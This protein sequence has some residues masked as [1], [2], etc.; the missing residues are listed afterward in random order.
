MSLRKFEGLPLFCALYIFLYIYLSLSF[1]L[2]LSLSLSRSIS[3][4]GKIFSFFF[5]CYMK[6]TRIYGIYRNISTWAAVE[7]VCFHCCLQGD[8]TDGWR[9]APGGWRGTALSPGHAHPQETLM[10]HLRIFGLRNVPWDF[11]KCQHHSELAE[12]GM[13]DLAVQRSCIWLGFWRTQTWWRKD[14]TS[15]HSQ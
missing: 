15:K 11:T 12:S 14:L 3:L 4:Y 5:F 13:L 2:S 10:F 8:A 9:Q 1:S 7:F 6:L